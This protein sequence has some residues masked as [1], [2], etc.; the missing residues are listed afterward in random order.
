MFDDLIYQKRSDPEAWAKKSDVQKLNAMQQSIADDMLSSEG[1]VTPEQNREFFHY[2]RGVLRDVGMIP[3]DE[4]LDLLRHLQTLG[5]EIPS[6][7]R[8]YVNE[9]ELDE[10][11]QRAGIGDIV[12]EYVANVHSDGATSPTNVT[13]THLR[14]AINRL[15]RRYGRAGLRSIP[16][17]VRRRD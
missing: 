8:D 12:R 1:E 7:Y 16:R 6:E 10:V 2:M 15:Y 9:L 3:S 13:A 14:E 17:P 4:D 5:H 11:R